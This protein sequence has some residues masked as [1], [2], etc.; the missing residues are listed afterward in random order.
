MSGIK[1]ELR[2]LLAALYADGGLL[3]LR[4][5]VILQRAMNT[6]VEL[7]ERVGLITNTKKTEAMNCLVDK[8][9]VSLSQEAYRNRLEGHHRFRDHQ[10][11]RVT[12]DV[13]EADLAAGSLKSHMER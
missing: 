3:A 6:L 4:D 7:F 1:R 5:P 11:R 8:I 12:C 10:R 9:R 13:C 2:S